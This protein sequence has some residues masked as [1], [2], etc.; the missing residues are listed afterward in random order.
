MTGTR[1]LLPDGWPRPKGYANGVAA[2]GQMVFV[3]GQIGWDEQERLV[4]DDF[5][6]QFRQVLIN[7]LSVLREAGAGAE[8]ICRMTWF[9]TSRDEYLAAL[10]AVGAHW[11]DLMGRNFPAMA[12]VVVAGLIEAG[13]KVEIET[14][15]VVSIEAGES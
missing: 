3:A 1:T 7:T 4:A 13:A 10:P 5:A 8:H 2:E 11:K 12:V 9:I 6:G 15:A 14:T